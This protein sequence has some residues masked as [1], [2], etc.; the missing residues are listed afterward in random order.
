MSTISKSGIRALLI[1]LFTMLIIISLVVL[2]KAKNSS[3]EVKEVE[4]TTVLAPIWFEYT[5]DPNDQAEV[6]NPSNYHP[7]L[8]GSGS[9]T[10]PDCKETDL[11]CAVKVTP[12]STGDLPEEEELKDVL[13][14]NQENPNSS[15]IRFK[16]DIH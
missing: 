6:E 7:I 4:K 9:P 5:G 1:T 2:V 3:G 13:T 10:D 11:L 14:R 16:N 15:E 12:D 8:D